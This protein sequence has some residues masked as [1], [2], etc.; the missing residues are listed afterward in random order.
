[1]ETLESE[2]SVLL[3]RERTFQ[4]TIS[5]FENDALMTNKK[6]LRYTILQ[7]NV[8]TNQKLYDTLLSKVKEANVTGNIDASN[9]RVTEEAVMPASPIKPRKK[10]NFILSIIFGL[11]TGVGLAFLWEYLDRSLR[12]EEDVSRYLDLPVLSIIPV[13]D[14]AEG[15]EQS[16]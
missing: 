15:K 4:M 14:D 7:R 16:K 11:M 6:Q 2:R 9:I 10:R 1:M 13:A 3:A 8:E 12:T 5:D